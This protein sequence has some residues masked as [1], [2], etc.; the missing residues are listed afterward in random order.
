[1]MEF[2][3]DIPRWRQVAKVVRGRIADGTYPPRTRVPSVVQITEEFGVANATA[4]KVLRSL[5]EAGLT[6][7]E[8]G[9]GSFVAQNPPAADSAV[10][11]D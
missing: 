8:P 1:M 4:H 10:E 9:L 2:V 6:Y 5:R 7:T 11:A 3:P